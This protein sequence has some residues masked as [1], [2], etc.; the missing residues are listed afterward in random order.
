MPPGP[1][2]T[3]GRVPLRLAFFCRLPQGEIGGVAL[4]LALQ[5]AQARRLLLDLAA[6][7]LAVV[8]IASNVEPDV[9]ALR[10]GEAVLDQRLAQVDDVG[11]VVGGLGEFVDG[12][13]AEQREAVEILGGVLL[14]QGLHRGVEPFRGVDE[15]VIDVGDICHPRHVEAFEDEVTLD[16]VEDDRPDHVA[17]VRGLVDGRPAEI[18]ADLSRAD[19]LEELFLLAEGVVNPETH[20]PLGF[21]GFGAPKPAAR[22]RGR[23]RLRPG[24]SRR[25]LRWCPP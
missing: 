21:T 6:G 1:P 2:R 23:R 14:R 16:R 18:H 15:L 9:A 11:D 24:R 3:P 13:D 8:A 19:R 7:E 10:V 25:S 22:P 5:V 20:G 12:V 17:D 4:A